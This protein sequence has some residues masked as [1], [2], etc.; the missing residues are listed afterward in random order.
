ARQLEREYPL[1][2]G[3]IGIAVDPAIEAFGGR[4]NIRFV[5]GLL[6][7]MA[8]LLVWIACANVANVILARAMSRRRELAIRSAIGAS[9]LRL[10]RQLLVEDVVL[11]VLGGAIGLL[12]CAW[13]VDAVKAIAG[14]DR[15]ILS[16]MAVD[17]RVLLFAL[18]VCLVAPIA[19]G[20]LP[21]VRATALRGPDLRD[22]LKD[23]TRTATAGP[24]GR[25]MRGVLVA[26]QVALAV[27]R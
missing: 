4:G 7:L 14:R 17:G 18:G 10:V 15:V 8:A 11:S 19:F 12:L 13:E 27:A 24:R 20:L 6:L 22:G 23:G 1:S 16:D 2:N 26:C 3:G 5:V 9:R 25:R 21:A